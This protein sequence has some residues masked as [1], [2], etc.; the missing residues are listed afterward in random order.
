MGATHKPAVRGYVAG[1]SPGVAVMQILPCSGSPATLNLC[2]HLQFLAVNIL[3]RERG[4]MSQRKPLFSS[5]LQAPYKP[6]PAFFLPSHANSG[7]STPSKTLV[8]LKAIQSL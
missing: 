2:Y 3:F 6:S 5:S 4:K 7:P 1:P 8:T